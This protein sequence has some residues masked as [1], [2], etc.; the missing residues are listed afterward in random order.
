MLAYSGR[1]HFVI[2]TVDLSR[3]V[4]EIISLIRA[5]G[6]KNVELRLNLDDGLP[7]INA[8]VSQLQQVVMNLVI[9]AA[10]AVGTRPGYVE[11]S[12]R[13]QTIGDEELRANLTR[14]SVSAGDYVVL[15]VSDNGTGM[16]PATCQRIFD[17][18]FTTKFT[19]RGLGLSSVLGIVRGHKG[20]L[21][22]NSWPGEGTTFRVFFPAGGQPVQER[23][24]AAKTA[25]S[26]GTIL[27][28]DDE[29]IVRRVVSA[30]L[31]R[32]GYTILT[33]ANGL[34]AIEIYERSPDSVDL[35]L[36]DMTMPLMGG[37]ETLRRLAAIKSSVV[38]V[39][40]SGFNEREAKVRFGGGIAAFVHK[41]FSAAQ[42]AASIAAVRRSKVADPDAALS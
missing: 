14:Q 34:E 4:V 33:A 42:L 36:L 13:V 39:A 37:E 8:D 32:Q 2:E 19:G 38:V 28:V 5:S 25:L 17:P 20:L 26:E 18:F 27:V 6:S 15:T 40:M 21:T 11:V 41:P 7:S 31:I 1:G 10:E 3:Q 29:E 30:V 9:N 35:V 24:A 22:V 12:T 23:P 16:D